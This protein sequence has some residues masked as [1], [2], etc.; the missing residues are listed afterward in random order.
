MAQSIDERLVQGV[1]ANDTGQAIGESLIDGIRPMSVSGVIAGMN[2]AWDEHLDPTAEDARFGEAVAVAT[3]ILEQELAGAAAF[4]RAAA[5]VQDAITRAGDPQVIELPRNMPWREPVL[6]GAPDALFVV[7][8]KSDGW[9]LQAVPRALGS[10]ENRRSL[11]EAWRGL[12]GPAL[13]AASGVAGAVFC[14]AAGFYAAAD[15]RDGILAL[16]HGAIA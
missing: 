9:G 6:G 3:R 13:I 2:P 11:P 16:A 8:P 4:G 15:S 10:F 7:Y 5:L 12:S 1:D 14:H